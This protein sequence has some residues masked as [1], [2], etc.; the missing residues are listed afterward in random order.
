MAVPIPNLHPMPRETPRTI[1]IHPG[2]HKTGTSSIQHL[3]W[4]NRMVIGPHVGLLLH[5]HLRP[6]ADICMH[7]SRYQN[8]MALADLVPA[9]D[10]IMAD[11][12]PP[13]DNRDL[14]LSCEGLSGNL[15]GRPDVET[16]AATPI[17]IAYLA[18]YF[19]DR[20]PD[21]RVKVVL[22]TRTG[23]E[24][25]YS[26]WRHQLFTKRLQMDWSAYQDRY[27]NLSDLNAVV[28]DI[29]EA[30]AP[31]PVEALPL[32]QAL[33][34]PKGPG[35]ALLELVDLPPAVRAQIA[36]VGHG[37]RGPTAHIAAQYLAL[38]R[39][40]LPDDE[41]LRQKAALAKAHGVGGWVRA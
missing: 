21:A 41:V 6:A 13:G 36:P 30:L 31:V 7:F 11:H 22:S 23:P 40:A 37:N 34:H 29:A 12:L 18:G 19:A 25:L 3:L 17:L 26:T 1:L 24:W 9:L 15:P 38:N 32:D 27:R 5:R 16:Y 2:F 10:R 39:S 20:C 4:T 33:A 28:T 14:I 8:L 35:G